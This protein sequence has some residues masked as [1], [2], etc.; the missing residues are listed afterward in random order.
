MNL[1]PCIPFPLVRGRGRF[2]EEGLS[3]LLNTPSLLNQNGEYKRGEASLIMASPFLKGR[4][5]DKNMSG[6]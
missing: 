3:P 1:I 6:R 2:Y 5:H 4:S